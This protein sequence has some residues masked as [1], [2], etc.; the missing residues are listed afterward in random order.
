[1]LARSADPMC[2]RVRI[3]R[4]HGGVP[5]LVFY[6]LMHIHT[7]ISPTFEMKALKQKALPL[8][9]S[10]FQLNHAIIIN[11]KSTVSASKIHALPSC[12]KD[13]LAYFNKR[14]VCNTL[15]SLSC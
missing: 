9:L 13:F 14:C 8:P 1:M 10:G 2:A 6:M 11:T 4:V 12:S 5:K 7:R 15:V 3:L